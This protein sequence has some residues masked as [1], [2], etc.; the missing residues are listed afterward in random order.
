MGTPKKRASAPRK[1]YHHGD[2]RRALLD[3]ALA[4][5]A[6]GGPGALSLREL[7][8][9]AG[10]SHAAPYRHFESREA[11]LATL[12][13][14]GFLGLGAEMARSAAGEEDPLL[15]F[16]A[17]GVAYVC[18]A[19]QHPGHFRVMFGAGLEHRDDDSP[20]AAA[21]A[22]TLQALIDVIA[23]GQRVGKLR[24]GDPRELALPAWSMVHGLAM[25]LVDDQLGALLDSVYA[26]KLAHAVIDV[27]VRGLSRTR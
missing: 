4:I 27:V 13:T 15:R 3:A 7:A 12:A 24:A 25:L 26:E 2:L 5:V 14:E 22:P 20:L 10:V 19:V 21:G 17:L 11:L 18:Y 16:R 8:R 1:P 23:V 6:A 9:K